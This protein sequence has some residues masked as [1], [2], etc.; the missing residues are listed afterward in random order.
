MSKI[1]TCSA[2]CMDSLLTVVATG[3]DPGTDKRNGR[4]EGRPDCARGSP[5]ALQ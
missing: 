5:R 2:L 4:P 3:P 1:S